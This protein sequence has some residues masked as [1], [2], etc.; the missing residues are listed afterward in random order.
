VQKQKT[1]RIAGGFESYD[2][3]VLVLTGL[4]RHMCH[5]VVMMVMAVGQQKHARIVVKPFPKVNYI[6]TSEANSF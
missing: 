5:R 1:R 6:S 4:R 3:A 2:C